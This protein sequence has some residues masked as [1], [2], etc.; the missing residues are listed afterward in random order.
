MRRNILSSAYGESQE[1]GPTSRRSRSP[2][3]PPK[4]NQENSGAP[5]NE[6]T[7]DTTTRRSAYQTEEAEGWQ[8][9]RRMSTDILR[10]R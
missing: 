6:N 1:G 4:G 2:T 9:E 3:R 10:K 5:A 8:R 7:G